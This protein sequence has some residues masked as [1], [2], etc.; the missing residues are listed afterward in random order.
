MPSNRPVNDG[1]TPTDRPKSRIWQGAMVLIAGGTFTAVT[2]FTI[3]VIWI[4]PVVAAIGG[5]F[6]LL[7]GLVTLL[8]G[9]E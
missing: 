3:G 1:P 5:L 6:W 2:H 4:W 7:V 8:T 9:Y